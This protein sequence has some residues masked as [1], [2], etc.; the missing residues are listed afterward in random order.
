MPEVPRLN[1][2]VVSPD[3]VRRVVVWD[4]VLDRN[5]RDWRVQQRPEE[6]RRLSHLSHTLCS[7][8]PSANASAAR[9]GFMEVTNPG[10]G[11]VRAGRMRD[12]QVPS[13]VEHGQYVR[14][15]VPLRVPFARQK[16]AGPS[17]MAALAEG[18]T[19]DATELA[20]DQHSHVR[21]NWM[22]WSASMW[23]FNLNTSVWKPL[24]SSQRGVNVPSSLRSS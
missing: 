23:R 14:H 2:L 10:V 4:R 18:V 6:S 22:P 19:D 15:H 13:I 8:N 7:M 1:Q 17:I 9:H 20:G 11:Q 24:A 21:R 3:D 12:H 5:V 16:V